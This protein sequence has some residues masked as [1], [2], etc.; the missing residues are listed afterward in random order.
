MTGL[1][2][3]TIWLVDDLLLHLLRLHHPRLRCI[4]LGR[5][6]L[7]LAAVHHRRQRG[8]VRVRRKTVSVVRLQRLVRRG[9]R[10]REMLHRLH[11][12]RHLPTP[13]T[14]L[15]RVK[16]SDARVCR[17]RK[18]MW[19]SLIGRGRSRERTERGKEKDI[20][21]GATRSDIFTSMLAYEKLIPKSSR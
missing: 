9:W 7:P 3:K 13:E 1:R 19:W 11:L 2:T 4:V 12:Q 5:R 8:A 14:I 17:W 16:I 21:T 10:W 20:K 6:F 15:H 18:M